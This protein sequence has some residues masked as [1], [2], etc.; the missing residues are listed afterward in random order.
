MSTFKHYYLSNKNSHVLQS[1]KWI[2]YLD[3]YDEHTKAYVDKSPKILEIGVRRGG[4]LLAYKNIFENAKIYGIDINEKCKQLEAEYDFNIFIGSQNDV[5]F[6]QTIKNNI[7]GLDI[8][9][10]DGSHVYKD[11]F[12]SFEH[13]YP[14][15]NDGG[16]YII[17]DIHHGTLDYTQLI[18]KD[19]D[20]IILYDQIYFIRKKINGN[21]KTTNHLGTIKYNEKDRVHIGD[22]KIENFV[23][24]Q[25]K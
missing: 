13:L 12:T 8:I 2:P 14:L 19:V 9:V 21:N 11:I 10:D 24:G 1:T 23:P 7:D 22:I 16:L 5:N 17:E 25:N 3:L 4:S 18:N 6:L 15:L 20:E